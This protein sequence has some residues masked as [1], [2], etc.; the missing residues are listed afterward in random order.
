MNTE[1]IREGELKQLSSYPEWLQKVVNDTAVYKQR[2]IE[3]EVFVQ[4]KEAKLNRETT[5]NFMIGVWPTIEQFPQYMA[6]NLLKARYGRSRGENM[7][8]QYLIQNIRVEQ[9][10]ADHWME[11]AQGCDITL[12]ELVHGQVPLGTHALSHWCYH[13]AERDPLA[14]AIAATNYAI[15][16]ATGEWAC[17]V[18]ENDTYEKSFNVEIRKPAMRWLKVHAHYDD[19]H[20]WEALTIVAT[21]LGNNPPNALVVDV[22]NAIRKSYEYM[23]LTLDSCL[24]D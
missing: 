3:H 2:V 18:C 5:R 9:K 16:G 15:E 4:M 6:L 14:V 10:H 12:Q 24:V 17:F 1:F 21:L 22:Y 20:P 23:A 7:A 11:W 13:T 19:T 8:R